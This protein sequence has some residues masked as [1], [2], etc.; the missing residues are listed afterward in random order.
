MWEF[1]EN[2]VLAQVQIF[3]EGTKSQII[4]ILMEQSSSKLSFA[5]IVGCWHVKTGVK[6]TDMCLL[7]RHVADM[8]ANNVA[9]QSIKLSN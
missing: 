7:G 5:G 2:S 4:Q 9:P 3:I 8:L 1:V 6:I